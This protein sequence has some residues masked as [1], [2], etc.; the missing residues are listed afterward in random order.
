MAMNTG[1]LGYLNGMAAAACAATP[2]DLD[3]LGVLQK[4]AEMLD[5]LPAAY[6]ATGSSATQ[7][8]LVPNVPAGAIAPGG[9][10]NCQ[11]TFDTTTAAI[12]QNPAIT[13][14]ALGV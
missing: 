3:T 14:R 7:I 11:L 13:P 1:A 12:K 10:A 6:V 4:V 9:N 2:T 8:L 5:K